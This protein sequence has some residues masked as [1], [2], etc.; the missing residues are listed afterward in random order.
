VT[1]A[2]IIVTALAVV[3]GGALNMALYSIAH[4]GGPGEIVA[5]AAFNPLDWPWADIAF[6][7]LS[8]LG[9]LAAFLRVLAPRTKSTLDDR[10]LTWVDK[11]AAFLARIVVPAKYREALVEVQKIGLGTGK[12]GIGDQPYPPPPPPFS[13]GGKSGGDAA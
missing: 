6:V 10:L 7:L 8:G 3:G 12:G 5:I 9:A 2:I 11:L 4:A 1:R 13:S